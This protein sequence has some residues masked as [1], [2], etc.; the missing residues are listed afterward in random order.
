M[1]AVSTLIVLAGCQIH[2]TIPAAS[3]T[4]DQFTAPDGASFSYSKWLPDGNPRAVILALHGLGGAASDWRPLGDYLQKRGLAVYAHEL[5]GMGNDPKPGRMGHLDRREG[6]CE[7]FVSFALRVQATHPEVPIFWYG[8]S[9]GGII[10][11]HL[12][13]DARHHGLRPRG[14]ILA[15]PIV[16]VSG[17]LPIWKE[18]ALWLGARVAPRFRLRLQSL[19]PSDQP[20]AQVVSTTT[21]DAQLAQ[22]PHAVTHFSLRMLDQIRRLVAENRLLVKN[23]SHPILVL[24]AGHDV[25]TP[26][27]EVEDFFG[28]IGGIHNEK[29]Y[30][31]QAYHLLLHDIGSLVILGEIEKWLE[32]NL[33][34]EM[35]F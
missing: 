27:G 20:P 11:T 18:W 7:D 21:H 23:N 13:E 16:R 29:I 10:G 33:K 30:F 5:R 35:T 28:E 26:P 12:L 4:H 34:K 3:W 15:S 9:L 24:Y 8:E 2:Q 14:F 31:P 1:A 6:W 22:T 32:N 17:K 19:A 25:F